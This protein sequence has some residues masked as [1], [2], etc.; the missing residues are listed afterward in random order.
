MCIARFYKVAAHFK[1]S[2]DPLFFDD[3]FKLVKNL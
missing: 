1:M 3:G 2:F